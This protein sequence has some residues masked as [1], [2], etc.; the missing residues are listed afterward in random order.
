MLKSCYFSFYS[1]PTW[2]NVQLRIWG[3]YDVWSSNHVKHEIFTLAEVP[4]YATS[5]IRI[6]KAHDPNRDTQAN[7]GSALYVN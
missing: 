6:L 1:V 3:M 2:G 4:V 5:D 7:I